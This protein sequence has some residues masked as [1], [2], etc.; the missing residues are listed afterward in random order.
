M[1]GDTHG[2]LQIALAQQQSNSI[3]MVRLQ[4]LSNC[5]GFGGLGQLQR[6]GLGLLRTKSREEKIL[7]MECDLSNYLSRSK[8]LQI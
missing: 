5:Q 1:F 7:D 4:D 3:N 2:A 8:D 6:A